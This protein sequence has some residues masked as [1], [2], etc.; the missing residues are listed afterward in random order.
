[1]I[2]EEA[3]YEVHVDQIDEFIADFSAA[4]PLIRPPPGCHGATLHRSVET[5]THFV[6]LVS[7][8]SIPDHLEGFRGAP[9]F[10]TWRSLTRPHLSAAVFMHHLDA[11]DI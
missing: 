5:P 11:L 1:V 3:R 10:E 8:E 6:L 4:L 7:W 2:T 9:E